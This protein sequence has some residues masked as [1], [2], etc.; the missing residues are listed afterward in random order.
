MPKGLEKEV[1]V[2]R[3]DVSS[4][5]SVISRCNVSY[6]VNS[7]SIRAKASSIHYFVAVPVAFY[8]AASF[9]S[10]SPLMCRTDYHLKSDGIGIQ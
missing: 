7:M 4:K 9:F 5:A 1:R 6:K 10:L 8:F 2:R 3:Q